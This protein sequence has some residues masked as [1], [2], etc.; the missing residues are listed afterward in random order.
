MKPL[1]A[2]TT[3]FCG[4]FLLSLL[5]SCNESTIQGSGNIT[6]K[7]IVVE[8]YNEINL[9]AT[10]KIIYEAKPDQPTYLKVEGD[11]NLIAYLEIKTKDS[12]LDISQKQ[13][14]N[15]TSLVVY[16]NSPSLKSV[17]GKGVSDFYLKGSVAGDE[18]NVVQEG[19]GNFTADNLVFAKAKFVLKG[20]S[21]FVLGGQIGKAV[22]E[23]S[24]NGN[25]RASQLVVND[26]DC[27]LNGNGYMQVNADQKLSIDIKG[28][29]SVEYKG[30]AEITKQN[31][32]GTGSIS[33]LR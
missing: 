29:G 21:D 6:S 17:T 31:I 16:T 5:T 32:S 33:K 3:L 1:H 24:G 15:P 25:I 13:N 7:E 9:N 28:N 2:I 26:L 22:Y 11:D 8:N 23:L 18:L 30:N 12:K 4:I 27:Q 10:A 14:I 20:A 19:I